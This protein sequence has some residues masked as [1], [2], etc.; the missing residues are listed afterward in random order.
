ME[1]KSDKE[2]QKITGI[3]DAIFVHISGFVSFWKSKK[4]AIK[5]TEISIKNLD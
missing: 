3:N 1:S 2:L 4:S 5:A